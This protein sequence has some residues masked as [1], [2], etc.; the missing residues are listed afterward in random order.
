MFWGMRGGDEEGVARSEC[1]MKKSAGR[2]QKELDH[3]DPVMR[4]RCSSSSSNR[5]AL[6]LQL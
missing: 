1:K 5:R 4:Q 6:T 2:K 3:L